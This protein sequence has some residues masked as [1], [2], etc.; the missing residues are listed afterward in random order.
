MQLGLLVLL[1]PFG[2]SSPLL[3]NYLGRYSSSWFL[4]SAHMA[5]CKYGICSLVAAVLFPMVSFGSPSSYTEV[6][7][8]Q[9]SSKV[10][11][12]HGPSS[13]GC[14]D[15]DHDITTDYQLNWPNTGNVVEVRCWAVYTSESIPLLTSSLCSTTLKLRIRPAHLMASRDR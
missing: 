12:A 15:T 11:C 10:G 4:F 2:L 9:Y 8:R 7:P 1:P 14:W 6:L 13:R 5:P 3:R